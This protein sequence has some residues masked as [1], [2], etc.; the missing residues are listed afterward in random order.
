LHR[1][2]MP[3]CSQSGRLPKALEELIQDD[4]EEKPDVE[5]QV[6]LPAARWLCL[7]PVQ[8]RGLAPSQRHQPLL[9]M[10]MCNNAHEF[11]Y[12]CRSPRTR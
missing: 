11:L 2:C 12:C 5:I 1:E 6:R 9:R 4:Q 8:E 3:C 7:H 10:C